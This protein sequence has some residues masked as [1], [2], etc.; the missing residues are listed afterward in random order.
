MKHASDDFANEESRELARQENGKFWKF[1]C[2][3]L[4]SCIYGVIGFFAFWNFKDVGVFLL[5]RFFGDPMQHSSRLFTVIVTIAGALG[6]FLAFV[7]LWHT[8]Y[9][10]D[11]TVRQRCLR[12]VIF[13]A[14]AA[15]VCLVCGQLYRLFL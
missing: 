9:R 5:N 3:F 7:L 8:L 11:L 1:V 14:A 15:A 2:S 4:L 13:C 10:D 12:F 6:W